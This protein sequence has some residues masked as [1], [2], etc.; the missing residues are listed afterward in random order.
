MTRLATNQQLRRLL[1]NPARLRSY[2]VRVNIVPT[3]DNQG[4]QC[5]YCGDV[6]AMIATNVYVTDW[7]SDTHCA[8]TCLACV[9][10]V[11]DGHIDT[12]PSQPV[13]IEIAQGA[14]P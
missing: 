13:T 10:Y 11:I 1:D 2:S 7:D 8:D 5:E 9:V 14:R 12:N 3:V 6:N 4:A